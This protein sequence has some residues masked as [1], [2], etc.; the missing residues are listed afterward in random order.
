MT[1]QTLR[2]TFVIVTTVVSVISS[3]ALADDTKE[4]R[5]PLGDVQITK[6]SSSSE[7]TLS[8]DTDKLTFESSFF[9][10]VEAFS[11][12]SFLIF[13]ASG[14]YECAG[15]YIW[16]TLDDEGLRASPQ[17]GTCSDRGEV[18][19]TPQGLILIMPDPKSSDAVSFFLNKDGTVVQKEQG[20]EAGGIVD[21]F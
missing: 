7:L 11:G 2:R 14:K 9:P 3:P 17:F 4:V 16:A 21:P 20:L 1:M 10:E 5:L 19:R 18:L 12:N 8:T 6:T 15:F 13:L